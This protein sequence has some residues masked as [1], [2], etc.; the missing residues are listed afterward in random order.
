MS[1]FTKNKFL[2][3]LAKYRLKLALLV[4]IGYIIHKV[5]DYRD[6]PYSLYKQGWGNI[7]SMIV[8]MG[9]LVRSWAAG[10]INKN[11][12][13]TKT[14]A[15]HICRHPLY[16]GSLLMSIGFLIILK[17]WFLWIILL[18]FMIFVYLP[19]IRREEVK[20]NE[21]FPGEYDIYKK[22]TG[23]LF[24][25]SLSMKKLNQKWSFKQWAHHT[26]YNAW[27]AAIAFSIALETWYNYFK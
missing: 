19:K 3:F 6:T 27:L 13:L 10:I 26:E 18:I 23:M 16:L 25:K 24:P 7:G 1:L 2:V 20:L 22:E 8:L 11:K 5:F 9:L 15:Y 4:I 12:I 21:I 17:D 14:G